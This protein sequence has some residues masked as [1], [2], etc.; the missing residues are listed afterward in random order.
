[1]PA[2]I[3]PMRAAS[4]AAGL[5]WEVPIVCPSCAEVDERLLERLG[6]DHLDGTSHW[7]CDVCAKTFMV[8]PDHTT[9][10]V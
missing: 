6:D 4:V 3:N 10:K 9:R 7:R 5:R 1:M 2:P 8:N